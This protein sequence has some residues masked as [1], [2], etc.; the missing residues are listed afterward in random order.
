MIGKGLINNL[1]NNYVHTGT[2]RIW[3]DTYE[4]QVRLQD[5]QFPSQGRVEVYTLRSW[6]TVCENTFRSSEANTVCRQLGYTGASSQ[7]NL[8]L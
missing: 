7:N 2:R 8:D 6:R 5:G 3:D 4:D 1:H